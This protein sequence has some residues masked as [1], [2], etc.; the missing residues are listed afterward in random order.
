MQNT[1][2]SSNPEV[3]KIRNEAAT[4]DRQY[5]IPERRVSPE[6]FSET[7]RHLS[8]SPG[9][10][11]SPLSPL[12]RAL[13]TVRTTITP[14]IAGEQA[15]SFPNFDYP[16]PDKWQT[17]FAYLFQQGI[18]QYPSANFDTMMNDEPKLYGLRLLASVNGTITDGSTELQNGAYC[19]GVSYWDIEEACSKVVGELLERY[20]LT[21]Y[22]NK[23]LLRSSIGKLKLLKMNFLDPHL[24]AQSAEWQKNKFPTRRFDDTTIF[25][26]VEGTSLATRE[27]ALIPAQFVFWNYITAEGEAR[28]QQPTTNGAGGMFTLTGATLS[29]LYELIQRDAFLVRWL[30]KI[31]PPRIRHESIKS[32]KVKTLLASCN[33]YLLDV[34]ILETTIDLGVPSYVVVLSDQTGKGSAISVGGGCEPEKERAIERALSEALGVR[35]WLRQHQKTR[36]ALPANYLPFEEPLGQEGRLTLWGN[37][38]MS[39]HFSFFLEGA[40]R[41]VGQSITQGERDE[42]ADLKAVLQTLQNKGPGYEA[43]VYH[44]KNP[45]LDHLGYHSVRVCVP[46]LV[47]LYLNETFAPLGADRIKDACL[48]LEAT[49]LE[50]PN[51]LPHPFP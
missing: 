14:I 21:I 33:R 12:M 20:P 29:G 37:P 4:D 45:A 7:M 8:L 23:D 22:K 19:R 38:A 48:T 3:K 40:M 27:K 50:S 28:I 51:P 6:L 46:A 5:F 36:E 9:R 25:Q 47:P 11:N 18:T 34:H 26:W 44:A 2:E 43:F 15:W 1:K 16:I 10:F 32:T 24:V 31:A 49:P 42:E 13:L 17:L 39:K 35:Y 41:D 30:N